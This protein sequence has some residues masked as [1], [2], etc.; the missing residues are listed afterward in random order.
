MTVDARA[1]ARYKHWVA[2][3]ALS[4]T[5]IRTVSLLAI[6]LVFAVFFF[7]LH[8][9][10]RGDQFLGDLQEM[11]SFLAVVPALFGDAL[12]SGNSPA[13]FGIFGGYFFEFLLLVFIT[14]ALFQRIISN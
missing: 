4:E 7:W 3:C 10:Y 8:G 13:E 14:S 12:S 1:V 2:P 5:L 6:T 9:E 11:S